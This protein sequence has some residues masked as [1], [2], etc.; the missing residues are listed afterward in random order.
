V[1]VGEDL[2]ISLLIYF[3]IGVLNAVVS[4]A[5]G[6]LMISMKGHRWTVEAWVEAILYVV[7]WFVQ[8][9][10][11]VAMKIRAAND[12]CLAKIWGA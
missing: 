12:W 9:S 8:F 4:Y 6:I 10:Y 2:V 5:Q 1:A 11:W 7:L 3:L